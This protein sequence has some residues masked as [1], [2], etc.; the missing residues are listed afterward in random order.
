MDQLIDRS[1]ATAP[2]KRAI[3]SFL[4]GDEADLIDIRGYAPRVKV[5]RV[6]TQL[7]AA[8]PALPIERV[9]LSGRSGCSDFIGQ[10]TVVANGL[11]H[12][13]EFAWDC[14]WKAEQV[15]WTDYFGMPD[16]IRAAREFGWDCFERWEKRPIIETELATRA[17]QLTA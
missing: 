14:R 5:E 3:L 6:L 4:N 16:Q 7:L 17:T 15:G 12:V 13:I 1:Q 2:F 8:E 11:P 10:V 9:S